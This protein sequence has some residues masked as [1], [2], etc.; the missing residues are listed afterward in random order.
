MYTLNIDFIEY[1]YK[2]EIKWAY[3]AK[4]KQLESRLKIF[5]II[6]FSAYI[7]QMLVSVYVI[8][9][10][11]SPIQNPWITFAKRVVPPAIGGSIFGVGVAA[12]IA[13]APVAPTPF[14]NTFHTKTPFGR[15]NDCEVGDIVTKG[16]AALLQ[17][18]F[19][20]SVMNEKVVEHCPSPNMFGGIITPDVYA[21][22]LKD[23]EVR[24]IIDQTATLGTASFRD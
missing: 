11:N 3:L 7:L 8:L 16:K 4:M 19:G 10:A 17:S 23:P 9:Y 1:I 12:A 20:L 18:K 2:I 5:G 15:G 13:E 6:F 24:S 22:M 14:S 21:A